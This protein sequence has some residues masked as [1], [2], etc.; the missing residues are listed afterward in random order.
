MVLPRRTSVFTSVILAVLLSVQSVFLVYSAS[1]RNFGAELAVKQSIWILLGII[2]AFVIAR[3]PRRSLFRFHWLLYAGGCLL[4]LSTLF[5]GIT[6]RGDRSWIDLGLFNAQPSEIMKPIMLLSMAVVSERIAR[7]RTSLSWGLLQLITLLA[8]PLGLILLQPDVGTALVYAGFFVLW[9]LALGLYRESVA[10]ILVIGAGSLGMITEV[11]GVS[12]P[13]AN[14]MMPVFSSLSPGPGGYWLVLGTLVALFGI[15]PYLFGGRVSGFGQSVVGV[16][17]FFAGRL[18]VHHLADY[19]IERLEAFINPDRAPLR[20]GYNIIQSQIAIGSGGWF[21]QGYLDGS[22]SQLGFIPELWTDFIFSVAV[23]EMGLLF[24]LF[25]VT[26][27]LLLVYG[28]FSAAALSSD[29]KGY[30]VCA[31][32]GNL[33]IVH[34]SINLGVCLGLLPVIGLPLPFTSY[35][36]S[37]MLTNWVMVGILVCVSSGGRAGKGFSV[38]VMDS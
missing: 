35:G 1:R 31:G 32:I 23:E 33:W 27:F 11:V 17:S 16:C 36:G 18:G 30:M 3:L 37:F 26:L 10:V 38:S 28:V 8:V 6:V 2:V 9:L 15:L 12:I 20:S 7:G 4:L 21:G 14:A 5:L 34:V 22:Q 24:G 29:L 25:L 19:Q 13:Y